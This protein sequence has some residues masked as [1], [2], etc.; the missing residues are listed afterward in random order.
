M[1]GAALALSP[2]QR[3]LVEKSLAAQQAKRDKEAIKQA[4]EESSRRHVED[5]KRS[6]L[7]QERGARAR[8]RSLI[9][10]HVGEELA[11]MAQRDPVQGKKPV[12]P[13]A[14]KPV[15]CNNVHQNVCPDKSRVVSAGSCED[16]Y[17]EERFGP[18]R[19]PPRQRKPNLWLQIFEQ[20]QAEVK[21]EREE[22]KRRRLAAAAEFR[23][24][25]AQ[26]EANKIEQRLTEQER[27]EE[28]AK[29]QAKQLSEWRAQQKLKEQQ[30]QLFQEQEVKRCKEEFQV[31]Q[32]RRVLAQKKKEQQEL[33]TIARYNAFIEE[34]KR[35]KELK[36]ALDKE[37]MAKVAEANA[38]QLA[39]KRDERLREAEEEVRLQREYEK[40]LALQEEARQ[41]E[42]QQI[43]AKQSQKVK[44]ALLNVKSAEEK[45]REDEERAAIVQAQVKQREEQEALKRELKR[46][47]VIQRQTQALKDQ[48]EE[49][50]QRV[51][52]ELREEAAYA[53]QFKQDYQEWLQKQQQSQVL[54]KQKNLANAVR[55]RAQMQEDARRHADE[56]KYGMTKREMALNTELLRKIGVQHPPTDA[57]SR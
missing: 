31:A 28:Y 42:L 26:Q 44:M 57:P 47:D 55:V 33:K 56:D 40:K 49:K 35:Q 36:K 30:R 25:L 5:I 18:V 10:R 53:H 6:R 29:Q 38:I 52:Q 11:R 16:D 43:I 48:K 17:D 2:A 37:E 12:R 4:I 32:D 1:T 3:S 51:Q 41:R 20:E 39:R 23:Q 19:R 8:D 50:K 27:E 13:G 34:E 21:Q 22:D 14:R 54:V 46:R 24:H 7:Q 15:H 45:A 9:I